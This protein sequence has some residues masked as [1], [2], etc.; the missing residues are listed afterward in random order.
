LLDLERGLDHS[1]ETRRNSQ[2][3]YVLPREGIVPPGP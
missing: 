2:Q 1:S 3:R